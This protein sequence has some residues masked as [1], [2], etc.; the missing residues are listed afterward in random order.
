[1]RTTLDIDEDLLRAAQ[2]LARRE[3]V[4]MGKII[5]QMMRRALLQPGGTPPEQT[6]APTGRLG[7]RPL[8]H[9]STL[10]T[11]DEVNRLRDAE[12]I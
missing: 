3:G 1:V 10:V 7:F 11:N 8:T 9:G 6:P 2:E 12:G 4:S 5:S